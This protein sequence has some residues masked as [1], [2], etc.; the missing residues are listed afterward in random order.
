[1]HL[2]LQD[3]VSSGSDCRPRQQQ[4]LP[5]ESRHHVQPADAHAV[6]SAHFTHWRIPCNHDHSSALAL[7]ESIMP[8]QRAGPHEQ[9]GQQGGSPTCRTLM[10]NASSSYLQSAGQCKQAAHWRGNVVRPFKKLV[11]APFVQRHHAS[12]HHPTP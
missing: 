1:M 8:M 5:P 11:R 6:R 10:L 3:G 2:S 9:H 12:L 4:L 7:L